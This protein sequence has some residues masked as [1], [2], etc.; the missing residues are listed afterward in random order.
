VRHLRALARALSV[1]SRATSR[2]V[3]LLCACVIYVMLGLLATQVLMR[4]F[5]GAPPSWTEEVAIS[6]F[7]WLVLLYASVGVRERF[8]VAIETIP[9]AWT[10]VRRL[11]E[12]LA[13]LLVLL[14]GAVSLIAGAAYVERTSGQT[15]AALQWPVE[16]LYLSVPVCG[17]LMILHAFA[18]LAEAAAGLTVDER[19]SVAPGGEVAR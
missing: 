11:C 13:A 15:S 3:A 6:L 18:L 5:L 9:A 8:H 10:R 17:G 7:T 16:L 2:L 14:F 19:S 4:Y 12:M 1:T